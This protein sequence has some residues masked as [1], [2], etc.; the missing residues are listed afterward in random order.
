MKARQIAGWLLAACFALSAA[1]A[2]V[3]TVQL[4]IDPSVRPELTTTEVPGDFL[5]A[6]GTRTAMLGNAFADG[7]LE[8]SRSLHYRTLGRFQYAT[9]SLAHKP[10]YGVL[11]AFEET[12]LPDTPFGFPSMGLWLK[13]LNANLSG[14]APREINVSRG[15]GRPSAFEM[16]LLSDTTSGRCCTL[17]AYAHPWDGWLGLELMAAG[18]EPLAS[19]KQLRVDGSPDQRVRNPALAYQSDAGFFAVVYETRRDIR[20]RLVTPSRISDTR[21][22]FKWISGDYVVATKTQP[23]RFESL[24]DGHPRIAYSPELRQFLVTWLDHTQ[25]TGDGRRVMARTLT[26]AGAPSGSAFVVQNHCAIGNWTCVLTR[27]IATG[28]PQV[29]A[30]NGGFQVSFPATPWNQP[31]RLWGVLGYRVTASGSG[32]G[33]SARWLAPTSDARVSA[34]RTVYDPRSGIAAATWLATTR[35][36]GQDIT[37]ENTSLLISDFLP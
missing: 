17:L 18:G 33:M 22:E 14:P 29:F 4:I 34:L 25:S 32:F 24:V 10:G 19:R 23:A 16:D 20:V 11:L 2:G 9:S 5:V 12:N 35:D 15:L 26:R 28:A 1:H 7:R 27:P 30:M 8:P 13:P 37:I 3:H 21:A 31:D 6:Y 36:V